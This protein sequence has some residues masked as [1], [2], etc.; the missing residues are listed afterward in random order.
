MEILTIGIVV[1]FAAILQGSIG[2]GLGLI[3]APLIGILYPDLLPVIII[4]LGTVISV[5]VFFRERRG[6]NVEF[7]LWAFI[8][9]V[10]GTFVGAY[11]IYLMGQ[12][13]LGLTI[14]ATVL[15]GLLLSVIGWA[16]V[17]SR[18]NV[19]V[20][21]LVSG[22]LATATGIGG[23]PLA[24]VMRRMQPNEVRP[25]LS[26]VFALGGLLSLASLA[27]VGE[28]DVNHAMY[29]AFL[30]PFLVAGFMVSSFVIR[31]LS[32]KWLFNVAATVSLIGVLLLVLEI[33]VL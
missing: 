29:T 16:P 1:F 27:V 26:A 13:L 15:I 12:E 24:L 4:A 2:F 18:S 11:A 3:A 19:A 10:P 32:R 17:S 33:L 14:A 28:L 8:G 5:V 21:G 31:H 22:V 23:P 20:A 25:T 7:M 30:S 6:I 9:R